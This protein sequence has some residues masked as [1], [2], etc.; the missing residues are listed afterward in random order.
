MLKNQIPSIHTTAS[1]H[2]QGPMNLFLTV[3]DLKCL[4]SITAPGHNRPAPATSHRLA[5]PVQVCCSSECLWELNQLK[6]NETHNHFGAVVSALTWHLAVSSSNPTTA[7]SCAWPP[8]EEGWSRHERNSSLITCWT[9]DMAFKKKTISHENDDSEK[10]IFWLPVHGPALSESLR[11][12]SS[13]L[14]SCKYSIIVLCSVSLLS[15]FI[16]FQIVDCLLCFIHCHF[17]CPD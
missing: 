3:S 12:F 14:F 5:G 4:T 15:W 13:F 17:R 8:Q 10:K 1:H 9:P 7:E 2:L 16:L 11:A 6:L